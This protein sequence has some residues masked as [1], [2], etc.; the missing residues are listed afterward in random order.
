MNLLQKKKYNLEMLS[1][2]IRLQEE[3][4]KLEDLSAELPIMTPWDLKPDMS[5]V[6]KAKSKKE[7][8]WSTL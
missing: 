4:L 6:L 3:F 5:N 1:L 8:K 7:K 2:L